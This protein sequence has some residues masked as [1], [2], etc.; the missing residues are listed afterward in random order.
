MSIVT[1]DTYSILDGCAF[2]FR[3]CVD[4]CS[5]DISRLRDGVLM[6]YVMESE[7]LRDRCSKK[8]PSM[9]VEEGSFSGNCPTLSLVSTFEKLEFVI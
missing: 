1:T 9:R 2:Y 7:A 5:R 8:P 3:E 4:D 6:N